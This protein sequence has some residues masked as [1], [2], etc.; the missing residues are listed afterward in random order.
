MSE[1]WLIPINY[2]G[3]KG[4]SIRGSNLYHGIGA[5]HSGVSVKLQYSRQCFRRRAIWEELQASYVSEGGGVASS[6]E[7]GLHETN[8]K[9]S[10]LTGPRSTVGTMFSAQH[11][12][13]LEI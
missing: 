2:E 1:K 13:L 6:K 12:E 9:F 3:R 10:W 7:S 8:L 11:I 4:T 5:Y